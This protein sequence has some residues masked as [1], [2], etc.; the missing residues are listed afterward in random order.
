MVQINF[1]ALLVA[2]GIPTAITGLFL[3]LFQRS[4]TKRDA[5]RDAADRGRERNQVL[6]IRSI[7]ASIALGE[8]TA[9][10]IKDGRCNGEMTKALEY[11]ERIKHEQRDFMTEQGAKSL[12]QEA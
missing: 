3:W 7:G 12:Y 11:A 5:K 9:H 8:A 2:M 10:A 6:L 4:I 1:T